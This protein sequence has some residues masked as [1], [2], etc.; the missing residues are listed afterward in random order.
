VY[1]SCQHR[2]TRRKFCRWD[3]PHTPHH[4]RESG[5]CA[6]QWRMS[7]RFDGPWGHRHV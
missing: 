2:R 7:C 1:D 5:S 3:S 6:Y 4:R